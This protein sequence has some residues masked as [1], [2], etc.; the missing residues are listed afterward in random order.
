[1]PAVFPYDRQN[2][3]A[4]ADKW[5]LSRNPRFYDFSD[6]GGDCT[7]FASQCIYAGAGRMNY[8]KTFGWYFISANNRAPA[9]SAVKFLHK[10]LTTNASTGP[11]AAETDVSFIELGDLIQLGDAAGM[12]YHSLIVTKIDGAPSMDTIYISTHTFDA[13]NR[14]LNS[15]T[16]A[17]ARFLHIEGVR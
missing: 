2:A 9:W 7:N 6:I 12:F 3:V 14:P 4:Y 11:F 13:H 1:M 8:T 5:A 10:F 15:Y 16:F 17:K